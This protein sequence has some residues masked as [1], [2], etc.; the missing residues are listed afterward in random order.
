MADTILV[1]IVM[2]SDSDLETIKASNKNLR[3]KVKEYKMQMA[4]EIEEKNKKLNEDAIYGT[5]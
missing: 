4:K 2:G 3:E 1:G 5:K